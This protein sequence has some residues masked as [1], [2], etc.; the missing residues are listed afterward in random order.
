MTNQSTLFVEGW[1]AGFNKIAFTKLLQVGLGLSLSQAK[2]LTDQILEGAQV[3]IDVPPNQL[4]KLTNSA[5]SLGAK[6]GDGSPLT[7]DSCQ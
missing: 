3:K 2:S 1:N 5:K 6:V 7:E 4:S